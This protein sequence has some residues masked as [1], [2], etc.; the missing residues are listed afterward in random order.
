MSTK[1][2][3]CKRVLSKPYAEAGGMVFGPKCAQVMGLALAQVVKQ[4]KVKK[5]DRAEMEEAEFK[6]R[7]YPLWPEVRA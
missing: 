4:P 6:E 2:A 1:C 7:Q 5:L 3:R